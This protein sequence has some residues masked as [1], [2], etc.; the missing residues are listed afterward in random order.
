MFS[1]L[2]ITYKAEGDGF[3]CD[4]ICESGYTYTF[5]FRNQPAPEKYT[6]LGISPLHSRVLFLFDQL[7]E[8]FHD[9]GLDNLYNLAKFCKLAY[10]SRNK[11]K[12]FGVTRKGMRGMPDCV[13]QEEQKSKEGKERE[14][15]TVKAA[16][17]KGDDDCPDLIAAS[18]YDTKPVH[19]LSM[20]CKE[21][22]WV[23]KTKKVWDK[24]KQK[25]VEMEFLRL[26]LIDDYNNGMGHVDLGDQLRNQYRFDHWMH[27]TK[28]WWSLHFWG[29]QVLLVNSYVAY[30]TFME[31]SGYGKYDRLSHYEFQESVAWAWIDDKKYWPDRHKKT[32]TCP[33]AIRAKRKH[34]ELAPR[35][36]Y[37]S[38][39][40]MCPVKGALKDRLDTSLDHMP[41]PNTPDKKDPAC[42]LHHWVKSRCRSQLMTCAHCKV[43]LCIDCYRPF[44]AVTDPANLKQQLQ[45]LYC[46]ETRM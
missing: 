33:A 45:D 31:L 14:R 26:N 35:N 18:I 17:L 1:Q 21:V 36:P 12:T 8:K 11:V 13:K 7:S 39:I 34:V 19:F 43:T 22:K 28:W 16:V 25:V 29:F 46:V 4:A 41:V 10:N 5:Y 3:Q 32:L 2:R 20:S 9:C 6:K 23:I 30:K 44:H 42:Q 24:V 15:G 27:K 40:S 37:V 38:D